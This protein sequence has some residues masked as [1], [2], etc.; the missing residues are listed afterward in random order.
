MQN[1]FT[2]LNYK[3]RVINFALFAGSNKLCIDIK[4]NTT[5]YTHSLK[6]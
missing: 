3:Q 5:I 1:S 2:Y 4:I 6:T